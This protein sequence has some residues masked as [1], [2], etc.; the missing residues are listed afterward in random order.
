MF[1]INFKALISIIHSEKLILFVSKQN[2][3]R[4]FRKI[5]YMKL[6]YAKG[7]YFK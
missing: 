4:K 1:E 5:F 7:K 3:M 6:S 2:Y